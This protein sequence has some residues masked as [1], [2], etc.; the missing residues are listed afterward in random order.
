[1]NWHKKDF[2]LIHIYF[3]QNNEIFTT[4]YVS[5]DATTQQNGRIWQ[6][7]AGRIQTSIWWVWQ[8][9]GL[10][11][12]LTTFYFFLCQDGSGFISTEELLGVLRAMGQNPTEDE[13]NSLVMEVDIDG[14]G[15]IDFEEF[16]EM[17][18][19]N[20]EVDYH[21]DLRW[22]LKNIANISYFN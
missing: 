10:K 17:M 19:K 21:A 13:L 3:K 20:H 18:R 6:S 16:I 9:I 5:D 1:M 12:G 14:N 7:R 2:F 15:T 11:E 22:T 8:S 4:I